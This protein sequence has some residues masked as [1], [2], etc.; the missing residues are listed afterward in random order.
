[1]K[2]IFCNLQLFSAAFVSLGQSQKLN[3]KLLPKASLLHQ[4]VVADIDLSFVLRD[5]SRH[6]RVLQ[7]EKVNLFLLQVDLF[8]LSLTPLSFYLVNDLK[9]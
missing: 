3:W 5:E 6:V 9:Q 1:M 4:S 2:Q 7:I 8:A